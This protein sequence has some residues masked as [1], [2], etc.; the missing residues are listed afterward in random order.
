MERERDHQPSNHLKNSAKSSSCSSIPPQVDNMFSRASNAFAAAVAPAVE[1]P[2]AEQIGASGDDNARNASSA[3]AL[4]ETE[5]DLTTGVPITG[6]PSHQMLFD[7]HATTNHFLFSASEYAQPQEDQA[8]RDES[9]AAVTGEEGLEGLSGEDL[10]TSA[11]GKQG[12]STAQEVKGNEKVEDNSHAEST[13]EKT[14]PTTPPPTTEKSA[15]DATATPSRRSQRATPVAPSSAKKQTKS[16]STESAK[17]ETSTGEKRKR[18]R[19]SKAPEE[20]D[21]AQETKRTKVSE[22]D[23]P[24]GRGRPAGTTSGSASAKKPTSTPGRG[25]GRPRK[26]ESERKPPK[27]VSLNPDGTPRGRGRPR[28]SEGGVTKKTTT[29]SKATSATANGTPRSRGRPRK[30]DAASAAASVEKTNA[31]TKSVSKGPG[32]PKKAETAETKEA[33]ANGTP[34]GRGRPR[35]SD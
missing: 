24:R 6:D 15:M 35:K 13:R 32:R 9:A 12:D 28:K 18:G 21:S 7:V 4:D 33:T 11:D 14:P 30:S 3:I 25:R 19:P 10:A 29:P 22:T 2:T 17:D 8:A 31:N 34:R 26:P 20:A 16:S 27:P 1:Q 5:T 23:T